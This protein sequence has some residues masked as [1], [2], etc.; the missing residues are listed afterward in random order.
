MDGNNLAHGLWPFFREQLAGAT[1]TDLTHAFFPGQPKFADF[2]DEERHLLQDYA[3]GHSC[4]VHHYA[5]VG[6]WG[7]HVDPPVH[8][9]QGGRT[10]DAIKPAEMVLPLVI[11][12]ISERV[13][14]DPDAV[15]MLGDIDAWEARFGR[16]PV[17]S[18]VALRTDWSQRW[19][20]KLRMSNHDV[21]GKSHC[22]GWS[23][24]VLTCLIEERGV[25]AIGHEQLDTDP[26]LSVSTGD[27]GLERYVLSQDR[28]QI[29]MLTNLDRVPLAGALI[30]A[31]WPKPK[32]GSG[33][34]ARAIAIHR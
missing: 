17:G 28:W 6:Q 1:F 11:L 2:P 13:A 14:R 21:A 16:I 29:E 27:D 26:G 32:G 30:I 19:P 9:I 25:T 12:D 33:F 5:H 23:Q 10:L 31:T 24:D 4:Q 15:P 22:P 18:F 34:P 3:Q 20:D 8:Y 7:T